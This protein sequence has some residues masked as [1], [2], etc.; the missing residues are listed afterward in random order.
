MMKKMQEENSAL[1]ARLERTETQVQFNN[2]LLQEM[3]KRMNFQIPNFQPPIGDTADRGKD[4]D[5]QDNEDD[6]EN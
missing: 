3:M 2:K 4:G 1:M 5:E 6:E